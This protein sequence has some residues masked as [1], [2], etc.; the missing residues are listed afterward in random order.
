MASKAILP[1]I[2][3]LKLHA[4]CHTCQKTGHLAR[5]C[6][7]RRKH[8]HSNRPERASRN[9]GNAV[10]LLQDDDSSSSSSSAEGH[11]HTIFQLGKGTRKFLVSVYINGVKLVMEIDSGAE[12]TT[13]PWSIFQDM[14]S[15]NI[16]TYSRNTPHSIT[17]RTPAEVLLGR[18]PRTRLSL[19]HPCMSQ[20]MSIAIEERVGNKSPRTFTV[21]EAMLLRDLCPSAASK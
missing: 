8:D 5:V 2:V 15:T 12:R 11:L 4:K 1:Q 17:G 21:G 13:I 16:L 18:S 3:N 7:S 19:I 6:L 14:Y 10:L 20:R 9:R